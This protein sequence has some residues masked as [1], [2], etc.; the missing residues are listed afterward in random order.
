VKRIVERR[1]GQT[2]RCGGHDVLQRPVTVVTVAVVMRPQTVT[3]DTYNY[4]KNILS[5]V[6]DINH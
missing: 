2:L 5:N 3:T 6:Y 4:K 1:V